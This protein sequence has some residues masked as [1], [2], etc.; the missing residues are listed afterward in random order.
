MGWGARQAFAETGSDADG[1]TGRGGT[2]VA[3]VDRGDVGKEPMTRVL[4][5]DAGR[6]GDRLLGLAS[7]VESG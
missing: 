5:T 2:P 4:A 3:V 7:A 6:L 1:D